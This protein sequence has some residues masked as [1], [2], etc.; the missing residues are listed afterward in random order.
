VQTS[1]RSL[2]V[3]AVAGAGKT[4]TVLR[5]AEVVGQPSVILAFNVQIVAEIKEK[6]AARGLD[7]SQVEAST[8][9]AIGFRNY[10]KAF[11]NCRKNDNKVAEI[12]GD[13]LNDGTMD[14]DLACYA[15]LIEKIVAY[16]KHRAIG[17]LCPIADKAAFYD[18]IEHFDLLEDVEIEEE[19]IQKDLRAIVWM[20][21]KALQRSY[22]DTE[23]VDFSDMI[24][25]PV[26]HRVRFWRYPVIFV[27]E[28]QDTN[29]ARRA[30]VRALLQPGGRVI[31]VG[32]PAQAIFGFTGAD[33]DSLDLIAQDF[34]CVDV[35]LTV[36]F[37]CPKAVVEMARRWVSHIEAAD[38]APAGKVS[39]E[40]FD[41]FVKRADLDNSSVV[42]CRNVKPLV[43]TA[44]A[45]IRAKIP[46]KIEGRDVGASLGR[47]VQRFSVDGSIDQMTRAVEQWSEAEITKALAAKKEGK[48]AAI[49]DQADTILAVAD[50][51]E[52][53]GRTRVSDVLAHLDQIFG[54]RVDDVVRLSTIHRAKGREWTRV[55][56]LD[57]TGTMP[58]R[59][60]RQAWQL[61]QEKN[62]AYVAAT[63]AMSELVEVTHM[64][65]PKK[66]ETAS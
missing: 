7:F 51:C 18:L 30:L 54:D 42:L 4:S 55:F 59:F 58:S 45:L 20:A 24:V 61:Q 49:E 33:S 64:P 60:A 3:I 32:D 11:P 36:T 34:D 53:E 9:H 25:M 26:Y 23:Q 22:K 27:D 66:R 38:T 2:R 13:M 44:F 6:L 63:R 65:K 62:L 40:K 37:R 14:L 21:Q 46:C 15:K 48:A 8:M 1:R 10:R 28:A 50:Q 16:A 41:A 35:P 47:L 56:W 29:A 5:M 52:E 31:A 17:I 19:Q 12:I 39:S 57:R 43:Q